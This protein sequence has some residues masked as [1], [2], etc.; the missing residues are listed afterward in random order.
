M[1]ARFSASPQAA[2]TDCPRPL[3]AEQLYRAEN[4]ERVAM[5]NQDADVGTVIQIL[6]EVGCH[7]RKPDPSA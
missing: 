7:P 4:R 6:V 2:T 5:A 1:S 3:P